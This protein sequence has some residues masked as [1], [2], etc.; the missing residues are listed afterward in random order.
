MTKFVIVLLLVFSPCNISLVKAIDGSITEKVGD[1]RNY[2]IDCPGGFRLSSTICLPLGY[3]RGELPQTPTEINTAIAINNIREI[4]DKKMTVSLE[5][6]PQ[7]VWE[8]KRIVTNFT[9][10]ER[11]KGKVLNSI[12]LE[13][14]WKPDLF[15]ENLSSFKL[16]SVLDDI[17]GFAIGNGLMLGLKNETIIWYEFSA[18]ATIYCNFQFFRY[19]MDKQNCNFTIGTTYPMSGAIIFSFHSSV[20]QFAKETRNTDEFHLDIVNVNDN[21]DNHTKFGFTINLNRRVQPYILG[22]YLP[23]VTIIIVTHISFIIPVDAVPGRIALLVTQFLTLTNICIYQ[24]VKK[25]S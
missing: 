10:E 7:L 13:K 4:D 17:S 6:H 22:C 24:Q 5:F 21:M 1:G 15:I 2:E 20:F 12:Y 18:K 23:C 9:T 25:V 3:R 16:H 8:D 14:V 19:P 11:M